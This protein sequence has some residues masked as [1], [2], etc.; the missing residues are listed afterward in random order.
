MSDILGG[1]A[2]AMLAVGLAASILALARPVSDGS[3]RTIAY[4]VVGLTLAAGVIVILWP[5]S[6]REVWVVPWLTVMFPVTA[7]V[8]IVT[9]LVADRS[10]H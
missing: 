7:V 4:L 8:V 2:L 9:L 5:P 10:R 3:R 6:S 1:M